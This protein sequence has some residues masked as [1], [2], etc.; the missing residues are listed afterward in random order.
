MQVI[1]LI[2][3]KEL[4][5]NQPATVLGVGEARLVLLGIYIFLL[6]I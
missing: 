4:W 2:L 6:T 1:L 3:K 5:H